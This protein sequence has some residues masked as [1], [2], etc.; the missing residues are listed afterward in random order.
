MFQ[1]VLRY[2]MLLVALHEQ[3]E[4]CWHFQS[5]KFKSEV[6][7][8]FLCALL[9]N[10]CSKSLENYPICEALLLSIVENSQTA[11]W[12]LNFLY[13]IWWLFE[14]E[15]KIPAIFSR[16]NQ[17]LSICWIN[18]CMND[19]RMKESQP[20]SHSFVVCVVVVVVFGINR[21]MSTIHHS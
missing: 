7:Y 14:E 19:A 9:R 3:N 18:K 20:H 1:Y 2:Y 16:Q 15:Q 21:C 10:P 8:C 12:I 6:L 17:N 4:K 5:P 13:G 11:P